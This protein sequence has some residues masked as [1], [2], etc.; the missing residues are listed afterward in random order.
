MEDK[1]KG[2]YFKNVYQDQA[3]RLVVYHQQI[4]PTL[5]DALTQA[6]DRDG[7]KYMHTMEVE[8]ILHTPDEL[9]L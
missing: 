5:E 1:I 2:S 8:Y 6:R 7:W 4:Y 3:G 9:P